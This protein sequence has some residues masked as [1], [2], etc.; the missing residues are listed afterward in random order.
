MRQ[1]QMEMFQSGKA[2]SHDTAGNQACA[3]RMGKAWWVLLTRHSR[4]TFI[5]KNNPTV[6]QP[7]RQKVP[8]LLF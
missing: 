1:E 8:K 7:Y 5:L 6:G 2:H 4:L 3:P